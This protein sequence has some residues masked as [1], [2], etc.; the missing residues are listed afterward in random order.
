M[1]EGSIMGNIQSINW[2][3]FPEF[4]KCDYCGACHICSQ[5]KAILDMNDELIK[6]E[7][8]YIPLIEQMKARKVA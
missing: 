8:Q 5:Q 1:R 7:F 6:D 3:E 4:V 2:A